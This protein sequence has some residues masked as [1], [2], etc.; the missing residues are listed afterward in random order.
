MRRETL[1]NLFS[2][3]ILFW[4]AVLLVL[5]LITGCG[6][7]EK[8]DAKSTKNVDNSRPFQVLLMPDNFPSVVMK[9]DG[10]GRMVYVTSQASE[11]PPQLMV[12]DDARCPGGERSGAKR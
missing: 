5:L 8:R 4:A 1:R 11:K 6:Q 3:L 7:A 12:V 9:C 2:I 10:G